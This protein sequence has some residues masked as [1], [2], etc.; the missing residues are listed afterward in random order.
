[1]SDFGR[2]LREGGQFGAATLQF[3]WAESALERQAR[4]QPDQQWAVMKGYL[5]L[6]R[7]AQKVQDQWY[8]DDTDPDQAATP[9]RW[10]RRCPSIDLR[11]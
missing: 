8:Y 6:E 7:V 4:D 11:F 2:T 9:S 10:R 1:M 3:R 5:R